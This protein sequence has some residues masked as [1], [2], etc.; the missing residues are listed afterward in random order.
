MNDH[1][2]AR[3][4]RETETKTDQSDARRVRGTETKTVT[5]KTEFEKLIHGNPESEGVTNRSTATPN[6][7]LQPLPLF[8]FPVQASPLLSPPPSLSTKSKIGESSRTNID[9]D[10]S[11][12]ATN[13]RIRRTRKERRTPA[14]DQN[15]NN[16]RNNS[17]N[18]R[19]IPMRKLLQG[20]DESKEIGVL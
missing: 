8:L 5:E 9:D 1:S 14:G 17:N 7:P 4:V 20:S 15:N 19:Q 12:R 13:F 18:A 16:N 6:P 3:R 11:E 2:D 10:P